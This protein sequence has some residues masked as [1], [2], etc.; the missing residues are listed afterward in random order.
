MCVQALWFPGCDQGADS[1]PGV[2]PAHLVTR[3]IV[4]IGRPRDCRHYTI[5]QV[6][7]DAIIELDTKYF[8]L[9]RREEM[10]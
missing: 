10:G 6:V 1:L 7:I 4:P 8:R 3:A 2:T 5:H 9:P